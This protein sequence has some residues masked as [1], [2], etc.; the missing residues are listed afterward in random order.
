M[1]TAIMFFLSVLIWTQCLPL[2]LL[3]SQLP[4]AMTH[5]QL[6]RFRFCCRL[7]CPFWLLADKINTIEPT[8]SEEKN[9]KVKDSVKNRYKWR[10]VKSFGPVDESKASIY[11]D[12]YEKIQK[13]QFNPWG[14]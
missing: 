8:G 1:G 10:N 3:A 2:Q 7:E 13:K 14:G 6:Q 5:G 11:R 4:L 9:Y 12:S